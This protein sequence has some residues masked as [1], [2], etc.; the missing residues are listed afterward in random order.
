LI[1]FICVSDN[2]RITT[3]MSLQFTRYLYAKDEVQLSL[4]LSILN[5]DDDA[6]FWACELFHSGFDLV[7]LM[8]SIYY[9][10][11]AT[12]NPSFEKY[13]SVKMKN[14]IKDCELLATIVGNFTIRP[15]NMDVFMLRTVVSQFDID[16]DA[17]LD[18][19]LR[20]DD[21]LALTKVIY[22]CNTDDELLAVY[23]CAKSYF[24]GIGIKIDTM[25]KQKVVLLSRIVHCYSKLKKAKMGKNLYVESESV[26]QYNTLNAN[27]EPRHDNPLRNELPA[28]QILSS[29]GLRDINDSISLFKLRRDSLDIKDAYLN[30]WLYHA[31]LSPIWSDR[32]E[33]FQGSIKCKHITFLNGDCEE[34]FYE[35]F[36]LEPDEQK[37]EIQNKSMRELSKK[38]D[39]TV[40][41]KEHNQ[42]GVVSIDM[43][44][45]REIDKVEF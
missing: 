34:L 31:S 1:G 45:I 20:A 2:N 23:K 24:E 43:G 17:D 12:L 44:F 3:I 18:A 37:K 35:H 13:L 9:D 26:T 21:Y 4:V 28:R 6:L 8:W 39:W 27:L 19:M 29:V 42:R 30:N 25:K 41:Y 16:N 32:I 40:F 15:H 38:K 33:S 22:D 36:G 7:G 10:F 5:K 11:F 14:G